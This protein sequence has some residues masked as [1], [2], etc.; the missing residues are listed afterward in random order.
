[1]KKNKMQKWN[2]VLIWILVILMVL[3]TI[4]AL[5]TLIWAS[6]IG[7]L[8]EELDAARQEQEE[9]QKLIDE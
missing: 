6:E 8:R 5:S 2:K 7:D 9:R 3:P 1:M 4:A